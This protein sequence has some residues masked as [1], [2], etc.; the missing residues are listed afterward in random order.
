M[1]HSRI[2]QVSRNRVNETERMKA[3]DLDVDMLRAEID[4][5]DYV[6]D[7]ESSREDDMGWL[8]QELSRVGFA[9]DG[10][11]I[12]IGTSDS[13]L[14]KWKEE[15]IKI[16]EEFDLYRMREIGS[17]SYFSRFYIFD[18]EIGYPISLW[19]WAKKM[20]G[21]SKTYYVGAFFDYHF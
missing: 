16:A 10:E 8:K 18:E 2:I 20:F 7:S 5:F 9:L 14:K 12:N 13:F 11:K 17:G 3:D 1:S 6:I 15:A 19:L 4:Y 21:E